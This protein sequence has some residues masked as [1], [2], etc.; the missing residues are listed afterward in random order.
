MKDLSFLCENLIAHRGYHNKSEGIPENS[1][2]AFDRAIQNNYIIELD[3]HI[4]KDNN[5]VVFHD[6]DTMRMTGKKIDLKTATLNEISELKL[7]D[8]KY[9]IPLFEEVLKLV[10]GK[11]PI[12]IELKTDN[13]PGRLEMELTKLLKNYNGKYVVK[14][15]NPMSVYWFKKHEPNIIRGQLSAEFKKDKMLWIKKF[16][17]RNLYFNI[18]TK[19][20]FV[21]YCIESFP[22]KRVKKFRKKHIVLGWTAR[23]NIIFEKGKKYCDNLICENFEKLNIK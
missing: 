22:N 5:I 4:L 13:K 19:P 12:I 18:L 17:L 1:I 20:D 7:N 21:S 23:D 3:V 8:T 16:L 11:V 14:S 10:N 2:V 9:K 15:F 6:N